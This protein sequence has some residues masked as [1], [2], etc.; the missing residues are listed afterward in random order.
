MSPS[1]SARAPLD[2]AA[3][4]RLIDAFLVDDLPETEA[5]RLAA[6]VNGCPV[7]AAEIGGTTR[8]LALLGSLPTPLPAPDLDERIYAAV[9]GDR[10]RRHDHRSWLANLRTQVLRGAVRTTGT[11]MVAIVT[12]AFLGGAF[13][14]AAAYFTQPAPWPAA[15]HGRAQRRRRSRRRIVPADRSAARPVE[16]TPAVVATPAPT[17]KP[18][19]TPEATPAP[20][21]KPVGHRPAQRDSGPIAE[22][23]RGTVAHPHAIPSPVADGEATADA[24]AIGQPVADP[25]AGALRGAVPNIAVTAGRAAPAA[26][27]RALRKATVRG[28]PD[29][30]V[31]TTKGVNRTDPHPGA[32]SPG[33]RTRSGIPQGGILLNLMKKAVSAATSAALLASLLATAVAPAALASIS[34]TSAGN[35]QQGTTSVGTA[36]FL[37]T[38][39]AKDALEATGTMTVTIYDDGR[40]NTVTWAG[41]PVISAPDSLGASVSI[42]DNV[43]RIKITGYDNNNVETITSPASRSRPAPALPRAPSRRS[44]TTTRPATSGRL[45][46]GHHDRDGHPPGAPIGPEAASWRRRHVRLRLRHRRRHDAT[47]SDHTDARAV[48]DDATAAPASSTPRLPRW[49]LRPSDRHHRH[50]D[51]RRTA[52]PMSSARRPRSSRAPSTPA[53]APSRSTPARTT[54]TARSLDVYEPSPR[55]FLVDGTTLTF[56]IAT[57]GVVFS[58]APSR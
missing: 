58:R 22:R 50:P 33:Q 37:F 7:C 35:V 47:F 56:T 23:D 26:S 27:F 13:V 39:N 41:T 6:H 52:P 10:A 1:P 3:A 43:R 40:G 29:G 31:D 32:D 17:A 44:S 49:R 51:R 42:A 15:C 28:Q 18:V 25:H 24:S 9:I 4:R 20:T 34:Q 5:A 30:S 36:T 12:V 2:H 38:E 53:T 11:L 55:C 21:A 14:L 57:A 46:L 16:T 8:L 48:T 19:V 54:P 45:R